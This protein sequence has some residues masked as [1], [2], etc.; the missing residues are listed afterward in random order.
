MPRSILRMLVVALISLF[1]GVAGA[2]AVMVYIPASGS[3]PSI[4]DDFN[5][6]STANSFWHVNPIGATADIKN[7][8]MTLKG[9]S[10]ELDRRLQTDPYQTVV[11]ARLR[12]VHFHKLGLGLGIYHSGT[13]G[14]EFDDDGIKCGRGTDFG[15]KVDPVTTWKTPPVNQWFYI[16]MS[17]TN[18]YP[19]KESQ[20]KVKDVEQSKLKPLT[21][22]C[23]A[24][25]AQGRLIGMSRPTDPKPNTHYVGLDEAY[26]RTWDGKNNYQVDWLYAG[27]P[28]GNPLLHVIKNRK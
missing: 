20:D 16:Q 4:F 22:V 6:S 10:I 9:N 26:I 19:T 27:P 1:L 2:A 7:G 8:T 14:L 13:I 25:D 28:G 5:W 11:S 12:A 18:P 3:A 24:Y 15:Y 23:T 21:E 17:I